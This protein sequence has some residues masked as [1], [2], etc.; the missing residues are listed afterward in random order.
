MAFELPILILF[1]LKGE[2]PSDA[3]VADVIQK[4]SRRI[5]RKLRHLGYLEAGIDVPVATGYDPLLDNEPEL[6]RSMAAS[7]R[8]RIA[9]GERAGEKV[10]RIGSGFGVERERPELKGPRCASVN[11]FSL[12]ANTDIPAHRRD[13]LECLIRY[14]ARGAVSLERLTQDAN[15]D[16][17]YRFNRPWSDGT[18]GIKLSPLELLEKLAALVPLPR[19]HLVRYSGCLA[20]HSKLRAQVIPSPRQQGVDG[21]ETKTGTPYWSWARLL[22]RVFDLDLATCPFCRRGSL[23]VI[24]AITHEEVITRI[25]RH[26]NLASVP[27]PI[28]PARLCQEIFAFD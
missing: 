21:D 22:G 24:A 28:A 12:H 17:I 27:P 25:L 26:L 13:Q 10:R 2:P 7:V 9:F 4:I 8:Q 5:I 15:G 14:T 3:D 11:G 18:T 1:F 23:R 6:A 20:P 19:A 16:L